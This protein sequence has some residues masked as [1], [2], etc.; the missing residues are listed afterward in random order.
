MSLLVAARAEPLNIKRL[1]VVSMV[2]MYGTNPATLGAGIGAWKSHLIDLLV[3][4]L[5]K[6]GH[7]LVAVSVVCRMRLSELLSLASGTQASLWRVGT[8]LPARQVN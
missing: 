2:S 4:T 6:P 7:S 1:F 8:A 3:G 5:G